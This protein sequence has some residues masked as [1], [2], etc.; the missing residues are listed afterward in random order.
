MKSSFSAQHEVTTAPEV[1]LSLFPADLDRDGDLDLLSPGRVAWLENQEAF[2]NPRCAGDANL[3]GQF[4]Q[5]DIVA[6]F[7]AGKYLTQKR[8]AGPK[9]IRTETACLTGST[10]WRL[11]RRETTCQGRMW[12]CAASASEPVES[13]STTSPIHLRDAL[14]ATQDQ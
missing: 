13:E 12:H 11:S 2:T 8:P 3:D 4:D 7:Q 5:L 1:A 14:F 10:S 6:A 9:G